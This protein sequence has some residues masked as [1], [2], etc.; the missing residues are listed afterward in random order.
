MLSAVSY[1]LACAAKHFYS[2]LGSDSPSCF[3]SVLGFDSTRSLLELVGSLK[4]VELINV[5]CSLSLYY[6][7]HICV[8]D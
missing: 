5:F 2:V 7:F 6:F 1:G 3:Y 4:N 8:Q